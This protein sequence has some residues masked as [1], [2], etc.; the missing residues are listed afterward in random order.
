MYRLLLVLGLLIIF[1]FLL[2]SAV[3][4]FLGRRKDQALT[5]RDQMVQD[6]VCRMYVPKGAAVEAS[7]GGQTYYFCSH[8]CAQTFRQQLSG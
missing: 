3:R 4:E 5:G 7:I 6:P 8:D 1:Y 2:R